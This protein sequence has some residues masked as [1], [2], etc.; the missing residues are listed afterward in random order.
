MRRSEQAGH[1]AGASKVKC[2]V[3]CHQDAHIQR[4]DADGEHLGTDKVWDREPANRPSYCVNVDG[5][6][7]GFAGARCAGAGFDL[8]GGIA[9]GYT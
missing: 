1:S 8:S 6:D 3:E 7:G 2:P 4:A 5:C 9:V